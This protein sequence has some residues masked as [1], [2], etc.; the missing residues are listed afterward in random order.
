MRLPPPQLG[1]QMPQQGNPRRNLGR[2]GPQVNPGRP[3]GPQVNPGRPA[4]QIGGGGPMPQPPVQQPPGQAGLGGFDPE[5]I[6]QLLG[7]GGGGGAMPG[8]PTS[9]PPVQQPPGGPM[10]PPQV[11]VQQPQVGG[12]GPMFPPQVNVQQPMGGNFQDQYTQQL[13]QQMQGQQVGPNLQNQLNQNQ[14]FSSPLQQSQGLGQALGGG[15]LAPQF[16]SNL[17]G[18][19][20]QSAGQMPQFS[21]QQLQQALGNVPQQAMQQMQGQQLGQ[22]IGSLAPTQ[23]QSTPSVP[24]GNPGVM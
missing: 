5:R 18:A 21:Q 22:G 19:P 6:K 11:N 16:L 23:S 3:I 15:Q 1:A 9:Q 20:Q 14:P 17:Q 24:G 12:S 2:P 7:G 13:M 4:P 8:F 10:F